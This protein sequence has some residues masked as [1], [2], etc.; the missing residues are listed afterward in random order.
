[1]R[2][3]SFPFFQE[4]KILSGQRFTTFNKK[5]IPKNPENK[6][7]LLLKKFATLLSLE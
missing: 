4:F 1:M 3:E 7:L 5:K 6:S 2:V